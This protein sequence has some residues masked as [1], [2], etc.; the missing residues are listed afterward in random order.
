[1]NKEIN[2]TFDQLISKNSIMNFMLKS[3]SSCCWNFC[4]MELNYGMRF[5][6]ITSDTY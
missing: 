5:P 4:I 1:M 2:N 3:M 6:I